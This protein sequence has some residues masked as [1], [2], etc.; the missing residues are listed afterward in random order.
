M[1]G[2]FCCK[3]LTLNLCLPV[4]FLPKGGVYY[5]NKWGKV[6]QSGVELPCF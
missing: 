6:G 5:P 1:S 2:V 4:Y 3:T